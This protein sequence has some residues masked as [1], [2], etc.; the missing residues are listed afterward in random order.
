IDNFRLIAVAPQTFRNH[1]PVLYLAAILRR[2]DSKYDP[3]FLNDPAQW[4]ERNFSRSDVSSWLEAHLN[5][6]HQQ[7]DSQ[8]FSL[9]SIYQDWFKQP[10]LMKSNNQLHDQVIYE[11]KNWLKALQ[12]SRSILFARKEVLH[13][14][15][16]YLADLE[17]IHRYQILQTHVRNIKKLHDP[18]TKTCILFFKTNPNANSQ[19]ATFQRRILFI[20]AGFDHD[21]GESEITELGNDL[22]LFGT[23]TT[24]NSIGFNG[25]FNHF[26]HP[27]KLTVD[28]IARYSRRSY[29]DYILCDFQIWK[30]IQSDAEVNLAMS[31]EEE[32]LLHTMQFPAFINGRAGSGKS[33]MLHYSFSYYCDLYL[34][35]KSDLQNI[36]PLFLTYSDRLTDKARKN[37]RQILESHAH[38]ISNGQPVKRQDLDDLDKSFQSFQSF[39][40][41]CLPNHQIDRFT[42]DKYVSFHEFKQRYKRSIHDCPHSPEVCWYAIRTY[43]KGYAFEENSDRHIDFLTIDDWHEQVPKRHKKIADGVFQTIYQKVWAWYKDL[44]TEQQLWDDQ[45]L[46]RSVL[47]AIAKG[48]TEQMAYSAIFC[49]EAQ[50]FTR[51]EFQ[52]I[53]RLSVWSQYELPRFGIESLPF[54]FAGDPMQTLNP[55]G[56]N[57]E[58][59]QAN[60][61]ENILLPLDPNGDR[62]LRS[63]RLQ[64]KELH[65]NYRSPAPIV[66][67]TNIIH[68]WRRV[69]FE[70]KE[71]CPQEPWGIEDNPRP[72]KLILDSDLMTDEL[73][74]I[75]D[76]GA[77]FLLP[78]DEGGEVEFI[79]S[80]AQLSTL[81]PDTNIDKIPPKIHT[82][83]GLKGLERSH[84]VVYLFGDYYAQQFDS[85]PLHLISRTTDNL[86]LEYFLNK[87]YVAVSRA[88]CNLTIIDTQTGEDTL[89][90]TAISRQ[91]MEKWLKRIQ[92]N[93]QD[94]NFSTSTWQENVDYLFSYGHAEITQIDFKTEAKASL[95][96]GI[97]SKDKQWI[98]EAIAD[99]QRADMPM[100]V[101]YCQAW[102]LRL[103][104]KLQAAGQEFMALTAWDDSDFQP[105]QDAWECFWQGQCWADLAVWFQQADPQAKQQRWAQAIQ[106]MQ[107]TAEKK[108]AIGA[109]A[110]FAQF[111]CDQPEEE[112]TI[113]RSDATWRALLE[114]YRLA[115]AQTLNKIDGKT[116]SSNHPTATLLV[117][118]GDGLR[119]I[120]NHSTDAR[121]MSGLAAQCF[122]LAQRYE[123]A[124]AL[125]DKH[126]QIPPEYDI[127]K[128]Q[129]I[130]APANISWLHKA[131][132]FDQIV[133]IW[134]E[135]GRPIAGDWT[136]QLPHIRK[137]LDQ[138][139]QMPELLDVYIQ[140]QQWDQAIALTETN[141][142]QSH[143]HLK[144]IKGIAQDENC[145]YQH[146]E[147]SQQRQWSE[148]IRTEMSQWSQES[149]Q[150]PEQ[151]LAAC[152]A[153]EKLNYHKTI[154]PTFE[155]LIKQNA[156]GGNL[157]TFVKERWLVVK[158]RQ[159]ESTSRP[160]QKDREKRQQRSQQWNIRWQDLTT[161]LPTLPL[162]NQPDILAPD[163]ITDAMETQ[164]QQLQ[165]QIMA[166]LQD[167]SLDELQQVNHYV[168]FV[169]YLQNT[170]SR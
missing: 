139:Q 130:A 29:P 137:A 78:C 118:W 117:Q 160:S 11:S 164:M 98:D 158:G 156:L 45:D 138:Q 73:Q 42:S 159:I 84:I 106:F 90:N 105:M 3:E 99:Y 19:I 87:L 115:I 72:R 37:V 80:S 62:K 23:K 144:I 132:L 6:S 35:Q 71:L 119:Q 92:H 166:N 63:E 12:D 83:S 27:E 15:L 53:L 34:K 58:S 103:G 9:P 169:R 127:A 21:P 24:H 38:Y 113:Y 86:Q 79:H 145:S 10:M 75:K 59:F 131:N 74:K 154:L 109:I 142:F 51:I 125:W 153:L 136:A 60:F 129:S 77:T 123:D 17:F 1:I 5:Q 85:N 57:W 150:D 16:L 96:E 70:T 97:D 48:E 94:P 102:K 54:A 43:I 50:D 20:L 110:S 152:I 40:L 30:S 69:L 88:T 44:Q 157:Q 46:A 8:D 104:K 147:L 68:L 162:S 108:I 65:Q 165:Q 122:Y 148:F 149:Q 64:L 161:D 76:S 14:M 151:I 135:H 66:K 143:H 39:L 25:Y 61:Y 100:A 146:M 4:A 155:Q 114:R 126:Q 82:P 67:F 56:F 36:R 134:L 89:W 141:L 121:A 47:S 120:A 41:S 112:W 22:D 163:P 33:T 31:G 170:D 168:N 133:A 116:Q 52:L 2:G 111:L 55:T 32:Q 101:R 13:K 167:L 26:K 91:A 128:G 124:I 18:I 49:D 28:S 107:A 95:L 93:L 7:A 140:H 81:F